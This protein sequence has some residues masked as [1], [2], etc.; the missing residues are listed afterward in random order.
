MSHGVSTTDGKVPPEEAAR[1]VALHGS[2][3]AA[4]II[5]EVEAQFVPASAFATASADASPSAGADTPAKKRGRP[6]ADIPT[7]E[8]QE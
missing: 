4:E 3:R 2:A 8:N 1:L 6:A 7:S 5:A